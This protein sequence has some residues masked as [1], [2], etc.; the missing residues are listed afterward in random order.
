[1]MLYT[2]AVYQMAARNVAGSNFASRQN[3]F[4]HGGGLCLR[5]SG[6]TLPI[7]HQPLGLENV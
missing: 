1:M 6:A 4:A 3:E 7:F 2:I 5:S